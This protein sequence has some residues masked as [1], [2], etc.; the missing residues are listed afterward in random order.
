MASALS[1]RQID[2][3]VRDRTPGATRPQATP[4]DFSRPPRLARERRR[5][6]ESA[7]ETVA[8]V[9][10]GVLAS[11]L[12]QPVD[13]RLSSLED[14]VGL[15]YRFAL[16]APATAYRFTVRTPD[17][18]GM[19]IL[20]PGV[21][22]SFHLVD[23][24]FGGAGGEAPLPRP[25]TA[26]ERQAVLGFVQQALD[27]MAVVWKGSVAITIERPVGE[28]NPEALPGVGDDR[29]MV[30]WFEVVAGPV[31][32]VVSVALPA[33]LVEP[34]LIPRGPV[35]RA[36]LTP[37]SS[38]SPDSPGL[39]ETGLRHARLSVSA[40]LPE[41]WLD[42]GVLAALAPGQV[43]HTGHAAEAPV[44]LHVNGHFRFRATL[45]QVQ[46]RVGVRVVQ[47]VDTPPS[48]R[49]GRQQEGRLS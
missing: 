4:Y 9:L 43:L 27:R 47:P 34:A 2:D 29:L 11:H 24:Q 19:G 36:R 5:A 35:R 14:A 45:G 44:E 37:A 26:L 3:L 13:V 25:L 21:A 28:P 32:S 8:D 15:E 18:E 12:R 16:G 41:L 22:L 31:T 6:L 39:V 48:D 17:G 42:A 33:A 7:W 20:D 23:R 40:R 38:P 46:R 49:P 10:R 30:A 1:Q